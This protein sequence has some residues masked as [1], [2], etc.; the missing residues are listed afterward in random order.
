MR[1]FYLLKTLALAGFLK[2]FFANA[3]LSL[4]K[5]FLILYSSNC[6]ARKAEEFTNGI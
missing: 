1:E 4:D 2:L 5:A 3:R 6:Q